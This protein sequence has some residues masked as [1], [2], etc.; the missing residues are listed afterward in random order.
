MNKLIDVSDD[1]DPP[2]AYT[3]SYHEDLLN[4]DQHVDAANVIAR[5]TSEYE[6]IRGTKVTKWLLDMQDDEQTPTVTPR[7]I[8]VNWKPPRALL[9]ECQSQH[10]QRLP[11]QLRPNYRRRLRWMTPNYASATS[12]PAHSSRSTIRDSTPSRRPLDIDEALPTD[13]STKP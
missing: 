3:T 4:L 7:K 13:G 1:S 11:L 6:A 8:S 12:M 9:N 2:P 5:T 10:Q